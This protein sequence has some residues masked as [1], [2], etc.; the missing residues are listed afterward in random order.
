M[1]ETE[2][3]FEYFKSLYPASVKK[4]QTAVETACDRMEYEG[5]PMY[6]EYPDRT[7]V[8]RMCRRICREIMESGISGEDDA[9]RLSAQNLRPSRPLAFHG[10]PPGSPGGPDRPPVPP[11]RPGGPWGPPPPPPPSRPPMPPGGPGG[12]WGPPPPPPQPP[13][14]PMPPGRPGGPWGPPPP[15]PPQPR[16]GNFLRDLI[17]VMLFEEMGARRC[18]RR[19]CP[20]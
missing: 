2:R 3:D 17:Q 7:M 19:N 1:Q 13:R 16:P 9:V 14:P 11:G 4:Y 12:P 10:N 6:D 20:R 15:P 18:R 8:D 5:S